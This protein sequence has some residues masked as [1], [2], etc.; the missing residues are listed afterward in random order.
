M[1]NPGA[2]C[3]HGAVTARTIGGREAARRS[4]AGLALGDAFGERW[5]PL[6]SPQAETAHRLAARAAPL[7]QERWPWTDDTAMALALLSVLLRHGEVRQDALAAAFAAHYQADP[8]RGYGA[9]MH[10]LL[11]RFADAPAEWRT[12]AAELFDGQ[13][14]L[15]NGAAMRVAPLG[16]WWAGAPERAAAQARLSAEVTHRHPEGV[17][18]AVAVAVAASLAADVTPPTGRALL[19]RVADHTPPGAVR[20]GVLRAADLDGDL[21]PGR[22]AEVLGNGSRLRADDT[23][24]LAL[25]S[26]AHHLDSLVDA[27]WTTAGALGDVDTTC[28]ITG[29]VVAAA[30]GEAG[31]PA[32]WLARREPLPD[33]A[34]PS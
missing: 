26:A 13:G 22:A 2:R 5:F 9:G 8:H 30:V 4:L 33:W 34:R 18:G 15:G 7:E 19:R 12:R 27:L 21:A 16:A 25:W 31:V 24:P 11:P 1:T 28:A 6:R 20:D 3:Q 10:R 17:A 32:S 29:G 23:V 14:S